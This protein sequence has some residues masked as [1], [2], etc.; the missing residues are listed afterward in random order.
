MIDESVAT[1]FAAPCVVYRLI[2]RVNSLPC[3]AFIDSLIYDYKLCKLPMFKYSRIFRAILP[4]DI[5]L[6]KLLQLKVNYSERS[7]CSITILISALIV[8]YPSCST[9]SMF[10][11]EFKNLLRCYIIKSRLGQCYK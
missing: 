8:F 9:L 7:V 11:G 6:I 1:Q 5:D 3:H 4:V 2:L 10:T